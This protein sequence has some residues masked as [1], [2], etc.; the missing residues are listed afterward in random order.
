MM[1]VLTGGAVHAVADDAWTETG[2]VWSNRPAPGA[3]VADIGAVKNGSWIELD[4]SSLVTGDGT[5]SLAIVGA[6]TDVASY[7]SRTGINAPQLVL[8]S[9]GVAASAR[10]IANFSAT[11]RSG[12]T[13]LSV[14]FTD[15]LVQRAYNLGLGLRERRVDRL[16]GPAS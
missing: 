14:Q 11:P 7:H 5:Y 1:A 3:V 15:T 8:M 12:P 6:V 16:G 9:R 10:P 13:P 4:V 2:I